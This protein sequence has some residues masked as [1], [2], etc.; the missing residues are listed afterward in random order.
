[1]DQRFG[2]KQKVSRRKVEP[3][4]YFH[5]KLTEISDIDF[6]EIRERVRVVSEEIL[7]EFLS[8]KGLSTGQR[9]ELE[10]TYGKASFSVRIKKGSIIGWITA[11]PE[12]LILLLIQYGSIRA[13]IDYLHR[14]IKSILKRFQVATK[15]EVGEDNIE[16]VEK[17]ENRIGALGRL[18]ELV[19]ML[20]I[21]IIDRQQFDHEAL[22]IIRKIKSIVKSGVLL[23]TLRRYFD[24]VYGTTIYS[25][26][27]DKLFQDDQETIGG[28]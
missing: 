19:Y 22:L 27:I 2:Y 1:M 11:N 10:S 4:V 23:Y 9:K 28:R 8:S 15:T 18:E 16:K 13:S 20:H 12:F 25:G 17:V 14:D 6:H 21:H 5:Y 7:D 24:N 3:E 26:I